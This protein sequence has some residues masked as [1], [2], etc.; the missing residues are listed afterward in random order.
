[1]RTP[2]RA[3]YQP[4]PAIFTIGG[5]ESRRCWP[6]RVRVVIAGISEAVHTTAVAF[7]VSPDAAYISGQTINVD[8]GFQPR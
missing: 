1:M 3:T 7:L 2:S 6:V 8:G 5:W 4:L